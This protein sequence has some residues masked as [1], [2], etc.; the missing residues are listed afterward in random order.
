MGILRIKEI[1]REKGISREDLALK[2]GV[3]TA[4]ISNI[5]SEVNYPKME[6][7][8][9]LAKILGVDIRELFNPTKGTIISDSEVD[10]AKELIAKGLSI[11]N[12]K[13]L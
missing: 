10:E 3:T 8:P 1:M 6:S 5:C 11:L 12:G 2:F 4:T 9:K 13:K 7:L